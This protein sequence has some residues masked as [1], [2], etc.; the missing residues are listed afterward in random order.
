MSSN[1]PGSAK[2]R[3]AKPPQREGWPEALRKITTTW[4]GFAKHQPGFGVLAL[5]VVGTVIMQVW[6]NPTL[7]GH[8][9]PMEWCIAMALLIGAYHFLHYKIVVALRENEIDDKAKRGTKAVE[10]HIARRS[11]VTAEESP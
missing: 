10:D 6:G 5:V 11:T 2:A 8:L 1:K 3:T 4:S 7:A 9:N